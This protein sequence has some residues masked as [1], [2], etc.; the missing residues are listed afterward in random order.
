M[1]V[2]SFQFRRWTEE[3]ESYPYP[4]DISF[5]GP[6]VTPLL[7]LSSVVQ[8]ELVQ[9]GQFTYD[10]METTLDNAYL[11]FAH[12]LEERNDSVSQVFDR[13]LRNFFPRPN[14]EIEN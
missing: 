13:V 6:E 7:P 4:F 11:N 8:D 14:Q 3:K 12:E 5:Y 2:L 10:F 1:S 9:L